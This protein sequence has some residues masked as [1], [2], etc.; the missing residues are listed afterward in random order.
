M[1]DEI[2]RWLQPEKNIQQMDIDSANS[3]DEQQ[4]E[5]FLED[6]FVL[7]KSGQ[8]RQARKKMSTMSRQ[9][10]SITATAELI[11]HNFIIYF[12]AWPFWHSICSYVSI[13]NWSALPTHDC[14]DLAALGSGMEVV[15]GGLVGDP[16]YSALNTDLNT[17]IQIKHS[18]FT[19]VNQNILLKYC[20]RLHVTIQTC[21]LSGSQ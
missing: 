3:A 13:G 14:T 8:V 2:A 11:L 9:P 20:T 19:K 15:T 1:V 16:L 17:K 6:I 18:L 5:V 21:L 12:T 10:S 4:Q 7:N